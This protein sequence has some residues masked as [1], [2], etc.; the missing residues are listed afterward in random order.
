MRYDAL[1]FYSKWKRVMRAPDSD[2]VVEAELQWVF[3]AM[4]MAFGKMGVHVDWWFC[5]L[6]WFAPML[7]EKLLN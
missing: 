5:F 3:D 4:D 1:L 7:S 6:A 2:S